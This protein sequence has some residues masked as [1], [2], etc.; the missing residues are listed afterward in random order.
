MDSQTP[1][2]Q[3][4]TTARAIAGVISL[5]V[6]AAYALEST[7]GEGT[8]LEHAAG[9]LRF[10]TIWGN[11]AAAAVMGS[12]ALS[13]GASRGIMAALVTALTVIGLVYW[14]LLASDHDPEGM[15]RLTN[16]IFHTVTPLATGAWWLRF[17]PRATSIP[18]LLPEIMVPPL[19][20]GAFAFVLGE[21]TGF[22]AYFFLDLP[23]LGWMQFLI[24]NAGLAAFFAALG[25]ALLWVKNA[26]GPSA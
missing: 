9:L 10:F 16:H 22:Y 6:V 23:Q 13:K 14:T 18:K 25:A 8:V 5:L 7:L 15:G 3:H 4:T 17:A 26:V 2:T 11:I 24:N 20:Y 19:S 21:W 1:V 12:I